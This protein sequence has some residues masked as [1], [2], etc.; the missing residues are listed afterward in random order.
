VEKNDYLFIFE[1]E[2]GFGTA[3]ANQISTLKVAW[4]MKKTRNKK[5]QT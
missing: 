5:I 2:V 1:H 4:Q 3:M